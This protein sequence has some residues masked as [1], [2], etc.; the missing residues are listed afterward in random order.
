[1]SRTYRKNRLRPYRSVRTFGYG[2]APEPKG[3]SLP[4]EK[5]LVRPEKQ[6]LVRNICGCWHC[7]YCTRARIYKKLREPTFHWE[8]KQLQYTNGPE[9]D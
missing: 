2:A 8:L 6:V 5:R 4:F 9:I 1:M 7:D 3:N